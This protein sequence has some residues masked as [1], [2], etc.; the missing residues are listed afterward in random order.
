MFKTIIVAARDRDRLADITAIATRFGLDMLLARLGLAKSEGTETGDPPDLPTRTRQALEALGPTYVKLGQILATRAD[1]L[2]EPWITEFEKL[3]SSAPT[4]PFE[5]LR[6]RLEEALGE[7]PETA[8]ARFDPVPLAAASMAQVHRAKLHD[9]REVVVKIRRPGIRKTMQADLRLITHLAGIVEASSREARRFQPQALVKQ[10]LDTVLEELDFTNEGRNADRLRE[11]L[12]A[13]PGVVVPVIH[14]RFSSETVLVIDYVEGIPPRDGDMLRAAGIDPATIADLGAAL[15]LDMVLVN[16]RFHGDPHP[17]NLL[18]LP[19]NRLALLDLG[20]I[21]HVS[22][23]RQQ[24]FLAFILSLRSGDAQT[25]A[26][27]LIIWSQGSTPSRDRILSAAEQLV[28]R[29]GSGPLVLGQLVADFFPLL[30]KEGLVLPPDLALIFKALI[31][32]DGVLGAIQPGFDLSDALQKARGRL[33]MNRIAA[34]HSPEKTVALLLELSRISDEAPRLLRAL[35]RKLEQQ[36]APHGFSDAAVLKAAKWLA[37]AMVATGI[38][39]AGAL[40]LT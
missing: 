12:A 33:V 23:R 32:M 26:D 40:M 38:I 6:P 30:R 35:T 21:G 17:G 22:A 9:G 28:A 3:H 18:C 34:A 5:T 27:T 31:T 24:E 14:W 20:L 36:D 29:H 16:G 1:L 10:L 19:G 7:P 4:L 25:L 8:F 13:N 2:P 11:D 37:G 15:V 39:I